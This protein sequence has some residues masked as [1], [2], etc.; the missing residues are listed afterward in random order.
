RDRL[1]CTAARHG[2]HD[3]RRGYPTAGASAAQRMDWG[4]LRGQRSGMCPGVADPVDRPFG[5]TS[6]DGVTGMSTAGGALTAPVLRI[7][8]L[9]A[10]Y[11]AQPVLNGV[12]LEMPSGEWLALLGPNGS[13]KSTLL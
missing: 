2:L 10:G 13:G 11:G 1:V 6:M 5:A 4:G 8:G 12:S 7:T 9:A 3:R